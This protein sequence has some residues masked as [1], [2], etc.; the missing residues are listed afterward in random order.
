A[1]YGRILDPSLANVSGALI[2]VVNEDTGFRHVVNS[3]PDGTYTAG[4]LGAG[5]YKVTVRKDG[6]RT[7]IRFHVPVAAGSAR[8][9]FQLVLGSVS[10]T[11]TV[12][13]ARA[14]TPRD[15][16]AIST[17]LDRREL[18]QLP[19]DGRGLLGLVEMAPGTN[20]VPATR[21]DAGQFVTDGQRPNTNYFAVDGISANHGI[22]AGGVPAQ[23][24]G[25]TLPVLS[26]LGSLDSLIPID[27]V[28]EFEIRTSTSEAR[29][30]RL[31]GAN[32]E[33]SSRS[34]SGELHGSAAYTFRHE[35]LG[36]ND[37]FANK[38]GEPRASLREN[39]G[40]AAL[41][42]PLRRNRTFFFVAY[43]RMSL[44][45]PFTWLAPVPSVPA[46]ANAPAWAEPALNLFPSPNGPG[47]G[48]GLAEWNGR[49]SRPGGLQAGSIRL[50]HA[51]NQ[52]V[53]LFTR[54]SDSPSS[55]QFGSTQ[56][57]YLNFRSWSA[58]VGL[59]ARL[60]S[61]TIFDMRLNR[62]ATS[63]DSYWRGA[64]GCELEPVAAV[65]LPAA[66]SCD[67][68]VRFQIDG[69]G[70][71][72]SGMEGNRRQSQLQAVESISRRQGRHSLKAGADFVR[73]QP[74]RHD[75]SGSLSVIADSLP[76][77]EN[78][79]SFWR[80]NSEPVNA[81]T[82]VDELSLWAHDSWQ[83]ARGVSLVGGIRWEYSPPPPALAG[84]NYLN[85]D[86]GTVQTASRPL[87]YGASG[88]FAPRLGFAFSPGK[89]GRT[90]LRVGGGLYLDSSL[91][92]ATDVINGG[93]LSLNFT[94]ARYG[95]VSSWLSYGFMPNLRL[96]EVAQW[97]VSLEHT[98]TANDSISLA[99]AGT[100]G[101]DLIRREVGGAGSTQT[102]LVVLTTNNGAS[103]YH[104]LFAQY[105]RRIGRGLEALASYAW[106][107]ALDN[108]SSDV[109]LLWA[110]PGSPA[111]R[112]RGSSDFDLRES[113]N[114]SFSYALPR[115][116]QGWFLDGIFR[117][118]S[119]FPM[120]V[121]DAEQYNG[122]GLMNALRPDLVP[123]E[124]V[125]IAGTS[126]PGGET[127]NPKAFRAAPA[128]TQGDLGRNSIAGFGM[129]QIDLAVRR[130]FRLAD[131]RAIDVRVEA[132]NALNHANFAD[133]VRYLDSPLFGQSTSML[134]LM[135][136][137]GSPGSGLAP[138][139]QTGGPRSLEAVLR[140]H[141]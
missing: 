110:G 46:R 38:A 70:Q 29:F 87:W 13:G 39:T 118:R 98:L 92:I 91:S 61:E 9:D 108:A 81:W 89:S 84:I 11:I 28:Q 126:A 10:E 55:N 113:F 127:L 17:T 100:A 12:D 48:G 111:A 138:L 114:A 121:L 77:L 135:L 88:H 62:S 27:S 116:M 101:W 3:A 112:D 42:G 106:S 99:Y 139:L 14:T 79:S 34:G 66:P 130:E 41:G 24:T 68:L 105:R 74:L 90:V 72:I 51:V 18:E 76:A 109:F 25:G 60:G 137:T 117:A 104:G 37:W 131:R 5:Y 136:G 128:G 22:S 119:G 73:I 63:A 140:F 19:L 1:L 80:A 56:V 67:L 125:W 102:A 71:V 32:L 49:D 133:P 21:G 64:S 45:E 78:T 124:P 65:F 83:I 53:S 75:A 96:P 86:T 103:Q 122:I 52:R 85:P 33:I 123:G 134:N 31:P 115:L 107:H 36:A 129:W 40:N 30:G 54:Y 15:Q 4:S 23:P 8:A 57:N 141:F 2:S 26:A 16:I 82:R 59:N 97:S 7:M 44:L 6:F 47:L 20:V 94:S 43:E 50:D 132:F 35:V 120:T 95:W 69:V 93:P 58:T